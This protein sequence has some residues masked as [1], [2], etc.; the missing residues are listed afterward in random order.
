MRL[1][2]PCAGVL[3]SVSLVL[4]GTTGCGD[5]ISS[6]FGG[7]SSSAADDSTKPPSLGDSSGGDGGTIKP[8]VDGLCK[9]QKACSG[10]TTTTIT[11]T[12]YDPA[13]AN[14]LYNV[15]VYVPNHPDQVLPITHGATC[16]RCGNVSGDPLITAI[17]DT[18]G[19]FTLSNVPVGANIPVIIQVGKWRRKLVIP[20]VNECVDNKLSNKDQTRLPRNKSEGDIPKI[21]LTTGGADTLECFLR[22]EKLGLDDAEFTQPDGDGSVNFY[23]G[24]GQGNQAPVTTKYQGGAAFPKAQG[25][26]GSA[27]NLK[28][29]DLVLLSCEG[30]VHEETKGQA[31]YDAMYDYIS[32]GGR[33]FA[34]HWHRIWFTG[35][36]Q[37]NSVGTWFDGNDPAGGN[38]TGSAD[39]ITTFPKGHDFQRWLGNV[40]ALNTSSGIDIVQPRHNLDSVDPK[41]AR[42]WITMQ[43]STTPGHKVAVEYMTANAPVGADDAHICGRTVFSDLHVSASDQHGPDWPSGCTTS[44]LTPQEKA[45]E[46][47]FFD[48]S[49]CVQNDNQP[50]QAANVK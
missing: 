39:I 24:S 43:D 6:I 37:L 7:G 12:V 34:T 44:G 1:F 48:L 26:W 19:E 5:A 2:Y 32:N 16:D 14:P 31:A 40:N 3:F 25:F 41:L 46:F 50:P 42:D 22:K 38:G 47:L 27:E 21:A 45:L 8:C 23:A 29:Y 15:L 33:M 10:G 20:T 4:L 28:K 35:N 17:T 13:G 36:Q 18:K 11:G 30:D 49:A 9:Q